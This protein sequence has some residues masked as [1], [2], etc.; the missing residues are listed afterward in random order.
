MFEMPKNPYVEKENFHERF[1]YNEAQQDMLKEFV[2]WLTHYPNYY[3]NG[4]GYVIS[5]DAVKR[6]KELAGFIICKYSDKCE[7]E[8]IDGVCPDNVICPIAKLAEEK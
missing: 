8:Q 1:I 7:H 2:E 6:L 4:K 5:P 3:S